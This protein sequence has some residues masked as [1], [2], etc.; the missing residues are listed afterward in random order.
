[1]RHTAFVG[2][3]LHL[4]WPSCLE[5]LHAQVA[6]AVTPEEGWLS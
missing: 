3:M 6:K 5:Q 2:H 1:M 4:E